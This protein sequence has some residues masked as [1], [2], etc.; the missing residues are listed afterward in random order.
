MTVHVSCACRAVRNVGEPL[1]RRCDFESV[2]VTR[3]QAAE[4]DQDGIPGL[5]PVGGVLLSTTVGSVFGARSAP[6]NRRLRRVRQIDGGYDIPADVGPTPVG[7][8]KEGKRCV[9]ARGRS[10]SEIRRHRR[11][12]AGSEIVTDR[13]IDMP[14]PRRLHSSWIV[15]SNSPRPQRCGHPARRNDGYAT[16]RARRRHLDDRVLAPARSDRQARFTGL[17]NNVGG[18]RSD[19]VATPDHRTFERPHDRGR[20]WVH[21]DG[22]L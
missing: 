1:A 3:Q 15:P 4:L 10:A 7:G 11:A 22:G 14:V 12:L 19:C 5:L 17:A 20:R 16:D 6:G 21:P 2:A 18:G 13:L 8:L 9:S